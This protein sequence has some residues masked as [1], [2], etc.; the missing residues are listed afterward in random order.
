MWFGT[1]GNKSLLDISA[2]FTLYLPHWART[3]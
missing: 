3:L 1:G 2:P